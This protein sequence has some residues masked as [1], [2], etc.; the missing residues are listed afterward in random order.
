MTYHEKR[1]ANICMGIPAIFTLSAFPRLRV[2]ATWDGER[3]QTAFAHVSSNI[4]KYVL[5]HFSA[6]NWFAARVSGLNCLGHVAVRNTTA[7]R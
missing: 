5:K 4:L 1:D 2:Q 7:L 3:L 6:Q